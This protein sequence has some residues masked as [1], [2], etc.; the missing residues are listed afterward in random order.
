MEMQDMEGDDNEERDEID[1]EVYYKSST[2]Q[3]SILK[4]SVYDYDDGQ[5]SPASSIDED[6]LKER[7]HE[8]NKNIRYE[9]EVSLIDSRIGV[10]DDLAESYYDVDEGSDDGDDN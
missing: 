8:V 1:I 2:S 4:N 7:N 10:V 6:D 9:V 5:L 3:P